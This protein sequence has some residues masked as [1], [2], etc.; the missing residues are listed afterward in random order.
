[1]DITHANH[2]NSSIS[3]HLQKHTGGSN[4]LSD[5]ST[6]DPLPGKSKNWQTVTLNANSI[7]GKAA[8][9]ANLVDFTKLDA[10]IM[11]ETK[12]GSETHISAEF[13]PPTSLLRHVKTE[14]PEA[15]EF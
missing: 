11:T 6:S 5:N 7:A 4:N 15:M 9:F 14:K 13:M 12:L 2:N 1:M 8:E 3:L 10:I